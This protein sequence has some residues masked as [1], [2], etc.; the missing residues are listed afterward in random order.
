MSH[1]SR[2]MNMRLCAMQRNLLAGYEEDNFK[3]FDVSNMWASDY[4]VLAGY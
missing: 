4:K 3:M 2:M 1:I